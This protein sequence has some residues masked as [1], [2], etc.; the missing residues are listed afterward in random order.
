MNR[1]NVETFP[2]GGGLCHGCPSSL[3]VIFM[4]RSLRFSHWGD[5]LPFW[6]FWIAWLFFVNYVILSA[7][8]NQKK[9]KAMVDFLDF[10]QF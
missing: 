3:I 7:S 10:F 2:V 8:L 6:R 4:G 1:C 5:S 9:S